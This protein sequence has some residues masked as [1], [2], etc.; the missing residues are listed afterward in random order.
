M[1]HV[2]EIV[3]YGKRY[4]KQFEKEIF[5]NISAGQYVFYPEI[6]VDLLKIEYIYRYLDKNGFVVYTVKK[7]VNP[8]VLF[9][10]DFTE[11]KK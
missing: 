7:D 6:S 2:F 9:V 1:T 8:H 10:L 3:S 11:S 4:W 5:E